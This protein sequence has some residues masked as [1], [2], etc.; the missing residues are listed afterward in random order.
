MTDDAHGSLELAA[1]TC[2]V[3]IGPHKTGS[4]ALQSAMHA[5]RDDLAAQGVQLLGRTRHDAA[6]YRWVTDRLLRHQDP[7]R[8]ERLWNGIVRQARE[9]GGRRSVT[10]SE[11]LSDARG[12]QVARIVDDLGGPRAHVVVT[13]RPLSRILPSQW[14][15]YVQRGLTIPYERWLKNTLDGGRTNPSF[16]VRH[17][18][19]ELVA[20]WADVVGSDR[21][22]I[23]VV[24]PSDHGALPRS[25]EALLGLRTGTL[26]LRS[27]RANRSLTAAEA[28]MLQAFSRRFRKHGPGRTGWSAIVTPGALAEVKKRRPGP[29][30]A[31]IVTPQWALDRSAEIGAEMVAGLRASGA[32]VVGDLSVLS[33]PEVERPSAS[34]TALP[35]E[36]AARL[37]LAMAES[38]RRVE[39]RESRGTTAVGRGSG[40][41]RRVPQRLRR[42]V[43]R[44]RG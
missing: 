16:W 12:E 10:S 29:D 30:E 23:V 19:D 5:A 38:G 40:L 28:A 13:L 11:F 1:G 39:R 31:A 20:R 4:T 9:T 41:R 37:A 35:V 36:A 18:S 32:R 2:L 7:A 8:G 43:R 42:A 24:D 17:R 15:Q 27:D 3:H 22:T 44:V 34:V 25:F 26:E 6:G 14:Q 33:T 21:M